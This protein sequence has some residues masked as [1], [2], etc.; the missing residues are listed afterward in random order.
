MKIK[1]YYDGECPFCRN[2][3]RLVNIRRQVN[4]LELLDL[5]CEPELSR[6]FQK[7]GMDPDLGMIVDADGRLYHGRHAV[8]FLASFEV[9][10]SFLKALNRLLLSSA[11]LSSITY[12]FMRLGRSATLFF[13]GKAGLLEGKS[14]AS[15]LTIFSSLLGLFCILHF[16]VYAYHYRLP[17]YFTS[18]LIAGLGALLFFAPESRRI[19][20]ATI[21]VLLIDGVFHAPVFSNHTIIKNFLVLSVVVAVAVTWVKGQGEDYFFGIFSPVARCLL[22]IM[23]FFGVFH[24]LNSGFFDV[25]A[26]CAPALWG[27]MPFYLDRIS[28]QFFSY[29]LIYGTLIVE[30]IIMVG[31]VYPKTRSLGVLAGISFHSMIAL[32]GYALYAPFSMLTIALHSLFI[33]SRRADA[34][35]DSRRWRRFYAFIRRPLG[36]LVFL[37][38]V[39]ILWGLSYLGQYSSVGIVW[40][41]AM[42][43]IFM[44]VFFNKLEFEPDENAERVISKPYWLNVITLIFFINCFSPYLGLKTG[45]AVNMFANLRLEDGVS[46]H[47][48]IGVPGPFGYVE[49]VVKLVDIEGATRLRY[50][51]DEDLGLV[52]YSLLDYLERNPEARVSFDRNGE[53]YSMVSF[54]ELPVGDQ[55]LLHPRWFR[56]WFSFIPVDFT[57]P[58]P[59]A[60]DR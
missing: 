45:Q 7:K 33:S 19:F 59:C 47:F 4:S 54:E 5:R 50:F 56:A 13:I 14:K 11:L 48:I 12:F 58:K 49:D 15:S 17:L 34:I 10:N 23:Y 57:S 9:E 42:V 20:A 41:L 43:P 18:Y 46:N 52:Y 38:L 31:L 16:L 6:C 27:E 21:I 51:M 2:Y 60:L 39:G 1:I 25:S 30:L 22:L 29:L 8:S 36:V 28:G 40:V 35:I 32:S 37:L 55:D 44:A 26:S 24:K 3:V 53:S